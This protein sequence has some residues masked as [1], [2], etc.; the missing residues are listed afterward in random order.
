MGPSPAFPR[1]PPRSHT[2]HRAA[3]LSSPACGP[4]AKATTPTPLGSKAP[5][6]RSLRTRPTRL[7]STTWPTTTPRGCRPRTGPA[8]IGCDRSSARTTPTTSSI[9]TK[10]SRRHSRASISTAPYAT[11]RPILELPGF[12]PPDRDRGRRNLLEVSPR[13]RLRV[14]GSEAWKANGEKLPAPQTLM[15][16]RAPHGGQNGGQARGNRELFVGFGN[17]GHGCAD[18]GDV[19]FLC[20]A[21]ARRE[22]PLLMASA[23]LLWQPRLR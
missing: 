11:S 6:T 14:R 22:R 19:V 21:S 4:T 17:P 18:S 7:T 2:A 8:G 20:I 3:T 16:G 13:G 9:S 1:R 5:S 10:T 12:A 23:G 15:A